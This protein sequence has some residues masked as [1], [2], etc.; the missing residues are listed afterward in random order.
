MH[1]G[2]VKGQE[3]KESVLQR[4]LVQMDKELCILSEICDKLFTQLEPFIIKDQL[5]TGIENTKSKEEIHSPYIT[6]LNNYNQ[7]IRKISG[8]L[9]DLGKSLET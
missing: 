7:Q 2:G 4:T 8:Q 3:V 5:L 9:T 1:E 6:T